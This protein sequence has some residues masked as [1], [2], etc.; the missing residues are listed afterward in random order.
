VFR[1]EHT[2]TGNVTIKVG[3]TPRKPALIE[4]RNIRP[5]E[6]RRDVTYMT[7]YDHTAGSYIIEAIGGLNLFYERADVDE[8]INT[9]IPAGAI[10]TFAFRNNTAPTANLS[11][12]TVL[13]VPISL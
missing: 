7:V 1:P 10:F 4:S 9:L 5:G 12:V 13:S 11:S 2:N 6:L 8:K 3:L